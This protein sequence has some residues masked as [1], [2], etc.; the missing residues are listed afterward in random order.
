MLGYL[1][2]SNDEG[3]LHVRKVTIA[4]KLLF[5]SP[6]QNFDP[7]FLNMFVLKLPQEWICPAS[8]ADWI[9]LQAGNLANIFWAGAS[10][11][12]LQVFGEAECLILKMA[13]LPSEMRLRLV[14]QG[15]IRLLI[16]M[17]LY[18]LN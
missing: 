6:D 4:A 14:V 13:I 11:V 2:L 7:H 3:S 10:L 5:D 18:L 12:L 9:F 8:V 16:D 17:H 15:S 1:E